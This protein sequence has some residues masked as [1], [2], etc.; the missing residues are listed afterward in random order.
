MPIDA[1]A[2][3]RCDAE[4]REIQ[5]RPDVVAGLA[6]AWLVTL[7]IEDWKR[8]RELIVQESRRLESGSY[9][10]SCAQ[11]HA[12]SQSHDQSKKNNPHSR[13]SLP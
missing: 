12:Q 1:E 13:A 4:I 7:G 2:L 9:T 5:E 11:S 8:E 3:A 6:P 10:G